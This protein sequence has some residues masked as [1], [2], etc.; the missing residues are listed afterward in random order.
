[1]I[2]NIPTVAAD[3]AWRKSSYSGA[4]SECVEVAPIENATA[5]RDSKDPSV[6]TLA[7]NEISWAALTSFLCA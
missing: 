1:M 6:G 5:I 2:E 7:V 3:L 4:Q